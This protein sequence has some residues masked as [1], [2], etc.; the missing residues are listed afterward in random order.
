MLDQDIYAATR[1]FLTILGHDVLTVAKVGLSHADDTRLLKVAQE[2]DRIFVTRDRDFGGLV[3]V[4]GQGAGV[5]Y[6]RLLP[7]TQN[8]VHSEIERVLAS[9]TESA[10]KKHLLS[11]NREGIGSEKCWIDLTDIIGNPSSRAHSLPLPYNSPPSFAARAQ[12]MHK[13]CRPQRASNTLCR[14]SRL[15]GCNRFKTS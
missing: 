6:L 13:R 8:A 7:S 5:I 10:L 3:F 14:E 9:H 1:R 2:Q 15:Y 4:G 12:T 11:L